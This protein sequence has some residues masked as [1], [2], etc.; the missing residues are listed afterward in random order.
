MV[1]VLNLDSQ[2]HLPTTVSL[3]SV[4]IIDTVGKHA[5]PVV[6]VQ[7]VLVIP[8]HIAGLKACE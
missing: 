5:L 2:S 6:L 1:V 7:T 4:L 8:F 3:E